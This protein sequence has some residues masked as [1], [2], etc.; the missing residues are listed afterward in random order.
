MVFAFFSSQYVLNS[1]GAGISNLYIGC[2]IDK[3]KSIDIDNMNDWQY[4]EWM[5]LWTLNNK[6]FLLKEQFW[7][8]YAQA[9]SEQRFI[10]IHLLE[11]KYF[12]YEGHYT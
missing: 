1:S 4:A 9:L 5:E 8:P 11:V 6:E 2:I 12:F 10:C 7:K 3:S